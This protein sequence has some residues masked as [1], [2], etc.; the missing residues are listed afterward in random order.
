MCTKK[1]TI[2]ELKKTPKGKIE[3]SS[4]K[5]E[6]FHLVVKSDGTIIISSIDSKKTKV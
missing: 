3:I 4:E 1:I 5:T 6:V 2:M